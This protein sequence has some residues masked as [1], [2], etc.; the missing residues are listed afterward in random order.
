MARARQWHALNPVEQNLQRASHGA[1]YIVLPLAAL[2]LAGPDVI[3]AFFARCA[4]AVRFVAGVAC[5]VWFAVAI[6]RLCAGWRR[7]STVRDGLLAGRAFCKLPVGGGLLCWRLP[8]DL[9]APWLYPVASG[10]LFF[11]GLW[12][13]VTGLVRFVLLVRPAGRALPEVEGDIA[14]HEF[15]WNG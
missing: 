15:D 10:S 7:S 13:A 3:G 14:A 12:L 8:H 6:A 1:A 5:A 2:W 11:L 9:L 4:P